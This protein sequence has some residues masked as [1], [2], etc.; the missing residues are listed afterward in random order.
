MAHGPILPTVTLTVKVSRSGGFAGIRRDAVTEAEPGSAAHAAAL[1]LL[2]ERPTPAPPGADGL[3][4]EV[5]I[6]SPH[7][8]IL[9]ATFTDP[10]PEA[11]AA[12][13]AALPP[14]A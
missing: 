1:R 7:R 9:H 2:A 5:S 8:T 12:L 10:L 11:V 6:A 3:R 14:P 4:Y 13:L